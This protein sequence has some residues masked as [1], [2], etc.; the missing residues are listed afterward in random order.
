MNR[1]VI[2]T[3]ILTL[4]CLVGCDATDSRQAQSMGHTGT[5]ASGE[6]AI[7]RLHAVLPQ[8]KVLTDGDHIHR[9]YGAIATGNSPRAASNH[10][11]QRTGDAFG[12]PAEEL[13]PVGES[14]LAS[15]PAGNNGIPKLYNPA[16]NIQSSPGSSDD[17]G[18]GLMYNPETGTYKFR[19]FRY[20]Q[21]RDGVPVYGAGVRTLVRMDGENQVVWAGTRLKDLG[22]F[23]AKNNT[24]AFIVNR[25]KT[26]QAARVDALIHGMPSP[27]ALRDFSTPEKTIF[28]GMENRTSPRM[29][30]QYTATDASDNDAQWTFVAD[31]ETGDI[32]HM[33]S[34][35]HAA[36]T[37]TVKA[38]V[39]QGLRSMECDL[40][41]L[42]TIPV[43]Y[44]RLKVGDDEY[45]ADENGAFTIPA[46]GA[47]VVAVESDVSGK[48]F[49][50][51]NG[52]G[53][54]PALTQWVPTDGTAHFVHQNSSTFEETQAQYLAYKAVNE[55]RDF[56]LSYMPDYPVI[57]RQDKM[58]VHVNQTGMA[59]DNAGGGLYNSNGKSITLCRRNDTLG[60]T[61]AAFA[62]IVHHEYGH[63]IIDM[64]DSGTLEYGE[65]MADSIAMLYSKDPN[66]GYGYE[67]YQCDDERRSAV[68]ECQY[69]A[70][71]CS[72]CGDYE[73]IHG[74][75]RLLSGIV[76]DIW[77]NLIH[78][79]VTNA[80]D[81]LRTLV[82][83][84]IL[85]HIGPGID[86]SIVIDMLTLDDTDGTLEN[87]TPHST[88]ICEAFEKHGMS[89][90]TFTR[91]GMIASGAPLYAEGPS[92]GPFGPD[93]V[94]YTVFNLNQYTGLN[95]TVSSAGNASW[96]TIANPAGF[97]P[98][99]ATTTVAVSINQQQALLL[100]DGNYEETVTVFNSTMGIPVK[101]FNVS[102]WVGA[103]TPIYE[104]T[105]DTDMEGYTINGNDQNMWHR[106]TSCRDVMP[107]HSPTGSL[108][109]GYDTWCNYNSGMFELQTATSPVISIDNPDEV[110][111]GFNYYLR[112][113]LL[114]SPPDEP[115]IPEDAQVSVSVNGGPFQLVA[116][117]DNGGVALEQTNAWRNE[118]IDIS[119]LM[120][121][122]GSATLQIQFGLDPSYD[123]YY[124]AETGFVVDDV[125]VYAHPSC[126]SNDQCDDRDPCTDDTCSNSR[127]T[128]VDNGSCGGNPCDSYCPSRIIFNDAR[129]QS[130]NLGS[131][132]TCH[133][134]TAPL[135]SGL[136]GN[137]SEARKLYVNGVEMTCD[138]SQHWTLPSAVNG[139]YCITTSSGDYDWASFATW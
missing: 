39:I 130:G 135:T 132:A 11:L 76:W 59:C 131:S 84:S 78:A 64:G 15:A 93:E 49:E 83:N 33:E 40:N 37:G 56:L 1:K 127:C 82:F 87:G 29:A 124:N 110:L 79:N 43:P 75:G 5:S 45:F 13:M 86:P 88:Q 22:D 99:G 25:E 26:L 21:Q 31:A 70:D 55:L 14:A 126:T 105:F 121:A 9:V 6:S 44:A 53:A 100:P 115:T 85:L 46:S 58:Y 137:F 3:I 51:G 112:L 102:L 139:G 106:S 128:H 122:S 96:L 54:L 8:A 80:D 120:P 138:W 72:S 12:V 16:A 90:P 113:D 57:H 17:D 28:A 10:F 38:D 52:Y 32:L 116:S 73:D 61:N 23:N 66:M 94:T 77:Q 42:T 133:E 91:R 35:S 134:T 129:Y 118:R 89:C 47:G 4:C 104:A 18:I 68:N 71:S 60:V 36:I 81:V 34:N 48:F 63:H 7:G 62:S 2:Y 20:S 19:L 50:I 95:Y 67:L 108:Y 41:T 92:D 24:D 117:L 114:S 125:I 119:H 109:C 103:P 30:M 101:S 98:P 107:G 123:V 69:S 27:E 111:L 65:G 97:I 136:C 74:C